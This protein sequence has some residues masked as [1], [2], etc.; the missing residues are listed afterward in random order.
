MT[1]DQLFAF[2]CDLIY[3][4]DNA[5]LDVESLDPEFQ[6]LGRGF[7]VFAEYFKQTQQL[8]K[9]LAK[10]DLNVEIPSRDNEMASPLKA[11]HSSLKHMTWQTQQVAKGD[12]QQRLEFMGEFA[13]AFNQM[14]AQLDTRQRALENDVLAQREHARQ[15]EQ[16]AY[17]DNLTGL[18]N[19][20]YCMQLLRDRMKEGYEFC[21]VLADLDN[22]KFVNDTFG[23]LEGDRYIVEIATAITEVQEGAITCRFGGDEIVVFVDGVPVDEIEEKLEAIRTRLVDQY[24]E[25]KSTYLQSFSF[26]IGCVNDLSEEASEGSD[27]LGLVDERMYKYKRAH[28]EERNILIEKHRPR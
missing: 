1:A 24:I 4:I 5:S 3:D 21:L 20:Y 28:R 22:L 9:S 25:G 18:Y 27:L 2:L 16:Y 26:G 10:G 7:L 6:E 12:Y 14:I 13:T 11:L 23:H 17:R 15:L 19:R 8:A